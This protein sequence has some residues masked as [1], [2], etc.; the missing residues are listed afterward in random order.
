MAERATVARPYAKAAFA[1]ARDKGALE[2]WS[3]WLDRWA[4]E[5]QSP[6]VQKS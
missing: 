2:Q 5:R 1:F 6:D 3:A 4:G